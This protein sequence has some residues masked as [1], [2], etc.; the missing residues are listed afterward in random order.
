[1]SRGP[2]RLRGLPVRR[3]RGT[4]RG[5]LLLLVLALPVPSASPALGQAGDGLAAVVPAGVPRREEARTVTAGRGTLGGRVHVVHWREGEASARRILELLELRPDLPGLPPGFPSRAYVYLAP[6]RDVWDALTGGRAPEWSAG[7]AIPALRRA[8]IPLFAPAAGG[9]GE[10][11]RTVLHEWAHLGL[12]EYLAGLRIP[13]WFDEGYAQR[14]S[15]GWRISEAWRLRL[16]LAGRAALPLDSLSLAWP[17][18]RGEAG[19]AYL[20]AGSA[21]AYLVDRSGDRG[22]PV[23]L[24]RWRETGDFEEAFRRTFGYSTGTFETRWVDHVRRRY[25]WI[26]I[27]SES[28]V[29]WVIVGAAL[30]VLARARARRRILGLARLRAAQPPARPAYWGDAGRPPRPGRRSVP[31]EGRAAAEPA[32]PRGQE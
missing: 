6:D 15:G 28:A 1:M 24:A 7:I 31:G 11:D 20:L 30:V 26:A 17:R 5:W 12:H 25:S 10:R 32:P 8:V 23:F 3:V 27:A 22:L 9:I 18:G 19:L 16:A 2:F 29:F 4:L 21:V 14:A 13:R